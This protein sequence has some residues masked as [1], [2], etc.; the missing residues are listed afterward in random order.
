MTDK[1]EDLADLALE[2]VD[3]PPGEM[4]PTKT[5]LPPNRPLKKT[6]STFFGRNSMMLGNTKV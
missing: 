4:E 6:E 3:K 5:K 2:S 1:I